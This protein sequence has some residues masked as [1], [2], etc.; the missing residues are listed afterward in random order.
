[1]VTVTS[2]KPTSNTI[3]VQRLPASIGSSDPQTSENRHI[4]DGYNYLY[5]A[6]RPAYDPRTFG[7]YI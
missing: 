5:T 2:Q 3:T 6:A 7:Q 1:M 4:Y